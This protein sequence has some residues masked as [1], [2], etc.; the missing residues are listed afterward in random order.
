MTDERPLSAREHLVLAYLSDKMEATAF[1]V[2]RHLYDKVPGRGSNLPALGAAVLG[3]LKKQGLV[4]QIPEWK[5]WRLSAAGQELLEDFAFGDASL[6][7]S[8]PHR[9]RPAGGRGRG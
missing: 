3:R 4:M 5:A 2:G 7:E 9:R 1:A 8:A 6:A